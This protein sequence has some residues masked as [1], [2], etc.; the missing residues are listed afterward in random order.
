MNATPTAPLPAPKRGATIELHAESAAF[1]GGC[2]GRYNGMAVFVSGCVP[3]DT[4]RAL[5]TKTRKRHA[6]ARTLE[7]IQPSP[8]RV[9]PRC[10]HFGDC[11]GCK[12]QNLAYGEQLRWKRQ[13]VVD[14]F[15]R[16]GGLENVE[17]R[18]T[19]GCAEELFYRNKM[20]FSF[21]TQRWLTDAEIA[22]GV[23]M[24][25]DFALGMHAA[26]R[27]DRVLDIQECWL[28]S[29]LSNRILRATRTFALEHGITIYDTRTHEGLL[30]NLVV[31]T[32][33]A[34]NETMVIL[35][36]SDDADDAATAYAAMVRSLLPEVTTLVQGINRKRAQIAFSEETRVLFGDGMIT[37]RVAG[38]RFTISPFSFFQ[39]NSLQAERL[40]QEALAAARLG[41][42][43][44][45]WD[46]YC[47]AGTITLA[48]ARRAGSAL[49]IELNEGSVMDARR[50]AV[51]NDIANARFIAG[52]LKTIITNR[53]EL[54]GTDQP[55]PDVVITD[56][57]RAGMHEDVVRALL[58]LAPARI[59]YV[60]CNP[61]TQARDCAL[62]AERY[63]VEYVQ[64]VDM[65]PQTYHV[66][67]VA[68]LTPI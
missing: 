17:V 7:V 60:S 9:V 26:G 50:N 13:H 40:Y 29:E 23:E 16:I 42:G 66:E 47:G 54:I 24:D 10:R 41:G 31:R 57:P 8:W 37:E 64:P 63:T 18:D 30:R 11:G 20:E 65:F 39:T 49:G 27:F 25:R 32:S 1:E 68:L 61:T 58:E 59:S 33:R 19:I 14:S 12:W 45:V 3:G 43:Q 53:A 48:A 44:H 21:G 55:S 6:E 28:Q 38:N 67:T 4:V 2:V 62:L 56:P 15:Q 5:V 52:D 34:T 46:L 35:V 51:G 36:T 22:S